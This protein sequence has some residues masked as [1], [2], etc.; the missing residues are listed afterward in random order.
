MKLIFQIYRPSHHIFMASQGQVTSPGS[1]QS[2]KLTTVRRNKIKVYIKLYFYVT[3]MYFAMNQSF[4]KLLAIVEHS[5]NNPIHKNLMNDDFDIWEIL[6]DVDV[7]KQA[8]EDKKY[9]HDAIFS[10]PDNSNPKLKFISRSIGNSKSHR[11]ILNLKY[12]TLPGTYW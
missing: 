2:G 9:V 4:Q 7:L 12:Y 3:P 1:R 10:H 5:T 6:F 8:L 11:K